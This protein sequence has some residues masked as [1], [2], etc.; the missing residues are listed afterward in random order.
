MYTWLLWLL[1]SSGVARMVWIFS[2]PL[3]N[4]SLPLWNISFP[5]CP[6]HQVIHPTLSISLLQK[7]FHLLFC[8]P[9]HIFPGTGA[10]ISHSY[11]HM[12]FFRYLDRSL[13]DKVIDILTTNIDDRERA[14]ISS[15]FCSLPF[16][17]VVSKKVVYSMCCVENK[18]FGTELNR[19]I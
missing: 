18:L 10:S 16:Q 12:P 17:H 5:L 9:L 19:M 15:V 4:I 7:S 1:P 6:V 11:K 3:W 14:H 2:L 13:C 8:L